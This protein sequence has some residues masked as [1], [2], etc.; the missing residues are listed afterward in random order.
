MKLSVQC[1]KNSLHNRTFVFYSAFIVKN[2]CFITVR[3]NDSF[4]A[5]LDSA[6]FAANIGN[7]ISKPFFLKLIL[8]LFF[9][10]FVSST[11]M[12]LSKKSVKCCKLSELC[13]VS[14]GL[15]FGNMLYPSAAKN[16]LY[17]GCLK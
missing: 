7:L 10:H 13:K 3:K 17:S 9:F 8:L 16:Y 11:L 15:I 2:F 14:S 5:T 12:M 6:K 1:I 4:G